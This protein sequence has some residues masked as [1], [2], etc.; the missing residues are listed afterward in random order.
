[1]GLG[2]LTRRRFLRACAVGAAGLACST[3]A[4]AALV[5]PEETDV[6]RVPI[7]L[8]RLPE[9]FGGLK[10]AQLSDLHYG[11]FTGA[12]EIG[13]AADQ[14]NALSPDLIVITGDFITSPTLERRDTKPI[15]N[16]GLCAQVLSRLRAPLGV[17]ACL[18]NHDVTV[19]PDHISE[20]LQGVGVP[21]LRN[22]NV[23]LERGGARVWLAGVDDALEGNP[24][25]DRSL[26]GIPEQDA[27]ILI[28]HEPDFADEASRH[29]VDLQLS[30]H[31][32]GGQVRIPLLGSPYLPP[33]ARKYPYG[34]YRVGRTQLYT[35]RGIGTIG[36]PLRL[37]APPEVTLFTL[38]AGSRSA[39][40]SQRVAGN[41]AEPLESHAETGVRL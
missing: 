26:A 22:R 12:R 16:A 27:V 41:P 19:D 21:V 37:D 8:A 35:N 29:A 25:M 39:N 31:S 10:I 33:L 4:Y 28:V 24:R 11:P 23:S 34:Y 30:G 1:M 9:A 2:R 6:E 17:F 32:H 40:A 38:R 14:V 15:M 7:N 3:T 36:L 13:A 20:V 5:E 18:G